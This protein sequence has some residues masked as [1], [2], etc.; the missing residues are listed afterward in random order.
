MHSPKKRHQSYTLLY[1]ETAGGEQGR[2]NKKKSIPKQELKNGLGR[3]DGPTS[4]YIE[5]N[6]T[7]Q[8]EMQHN[9]TQEARL[10][11]AQELRGRRGR[12][13][14]GLGSGIGW[15]LCKQLQTLSHSLLTE[16]RSQ[17]TGQHFGWGIPFLHNCAYTPNTATPELPSKDI[18]SS[19][20]VQTL[21]LTTAKKK[22]NT[23][24]FF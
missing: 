9:S 21:T 11:A 10:G 14:W 1:A 19:Q 15:D 13:N 16:A 22:I 20:S 17:S 5:K 2:S 8:Q 4:S 6:Q 24:L 23:S 7:H 12:T 18:L 3:R